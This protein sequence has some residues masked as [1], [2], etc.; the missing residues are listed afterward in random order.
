[1]IP[2]NEGLRF[3]V[4]GLGFLGFLEFSVWGLGFSRVSEGGFLSIQDRAKQL[5]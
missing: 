2:S 3:R 4:Q 5:W 1:M